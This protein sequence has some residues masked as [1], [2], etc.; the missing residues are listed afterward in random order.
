MNIQEVNS[1]SWLECVC[2][3]LLLSFREMARVFKAKHVCG[4]ICKTQAKIEI[5]PIAVAQREVQLQLLACWKKVFFYCAL[6]INK[7]KK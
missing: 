6:K 4:I 2:T 7:Q 5:F 3:C 1:R